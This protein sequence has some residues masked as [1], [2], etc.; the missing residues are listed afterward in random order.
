MSDVP[1]G[2]RETPL[3]PLPE[4]WEVVRLGE[5]L[6][7]RIEKVEVKPDE[8]YTRLGVHWYA[9]GPFKK[10]V[11]LGEEIRSK[12]LYKVEPEHFIY[13]RLFG[14]KGSFGVVSE[15]MADCHVS[16]EFPLFRVAGEIADPCYLWRWFSQSSVWKRIEDQSMGSTRTSRLRLKVAD[17]L[18]ME[19]PL[20][21]L[22]EQRAIAHVLRTVQRARE[23]TE[24][25]IAAVRELKRSLMRHLFTYG[26]VPVG[27][28]ER[29]ELQETEIGPIPA[30]WKVA[31]L[32][33]WAHLVTK[34]SSPTW[35]GFDYCD[36][37][38][39]FVRSQNVGWGTL[40]LFDV[41]HLP[42]A[43]NRQ[44]R[45]SVLQEG[46]LLINIV[47]ASIGRTALADG[48]VEGGN[49][50]QAV[51]VVRLKEG[52]D[53]RFA[54]DFLFTEAGQY[55]MHR[56]KKEIARANISLQDIRNFSVPLAGRSEQREIARILST[57][58]AKTAAEE[59][60]REALDGLFH[61][62]L[63]HL[64][65][66]RIRTQEFQRQAART[67]SREEESLGDFAP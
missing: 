54:M 4:T 38:V 9:A 42:E 32:G 39:V 15:D 67:P 17:L 65:T 22:P 8:E 37:G 23:A 2:F 47:G 61:S 43:F 45:R 10:D 1:E 5:V 52:L 62:L 60:R 14:W 44:Q 58:D 19:V 18:A 29:V 55:Q 57:V 50:N 64:M 7:Q 53:P 49:V 59:A 12:Y 25:V 36:D 16:S 3:G 6:E 46:D 11:V 56:Q 41:A 63:H 34:G 30:H 26:P 48:R 51:A 31:Q 28:A 66:G 20:P 27:E 35:Q 13:N 21:P 24:G 40:D 33:E